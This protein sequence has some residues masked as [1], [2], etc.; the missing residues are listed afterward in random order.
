MSPHRGTKSCKDNCRSRG[1]FE[2]KAAGCLTLTC[3]CH[4]AKLIPHCCESA[5]LEKGTL[6][7]G[8]PGTGGGL[9]STEWALQ[10]EATGTEAISVG[11]HHQ[12]TKELAVNLNHGHQ[13]GKERVKCIDSLKTFQKAELSKRPD[14]QDS[15]DNESSRKSLD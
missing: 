7:A 8:R 1:H 3:Y 5:A 15:G 12:G 14:V 13:T 6:H 9:S 2:V 11:S 10:G 4:A